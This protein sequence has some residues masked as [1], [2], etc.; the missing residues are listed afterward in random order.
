MSVA[1]D[2][3]PQHT[4]PAFDL[5]ENTRDHIFVTGRAGTGKS[6]LLRYFQENTHKRIVTLAPTGVAA[7][8]VRG[9]TIHSFFKFGPGVT[10]E[11]IKEKRFRK[12][13]IYKELDTIL[14]DE[15]SMVR[16]DL[17]D[18]VDTFLRMFGPDRK[19]P[20]GGIQMILIGDLHQLPPVV[21]RDEESIF[22]KT[23][24]LAKNY[25]KDSQREGEFYPGM[26]EGPFF[27]NA[28]AFEKIQLRYI[29]LQT[30]YRQSD[31]SFVEILDAIRTGDVTD[32][33]LEAINQRVEDLE[34]A[35]LD[36]DAEGGPSYVY[37]ATTNAIVER[38]NDMK[39]KKLA[40]TG[41]LAFKGLIRGEFNTRDLPTAEKLIIKPGAQVMLL[42]N[43]PKDRWVNGD[44]GKV[45][46]IQQPGKQAKEPQDDRIILDADGEPFDPDAE[47]GAI[48]TFQKRQEEKMARFPKI[49]VQLTDGREVEV[50]PITWD[51]NTFVYNQEDQKIES[52]II[53][54]FMQYP[55][56]L[57]WAVTVHK[58][59]GKT[60]EKVIVDFGNGTF[61]HG[62]AYVALSRATTLEGMILRTPL[63][64]HHIIFDKRVKEFHEKLASKPFKK[65]DLF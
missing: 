10:V 41:G 11:N 1:Q 8:N 14:I 33:Q 6:T 3:Q 35:M 5:L 54:S 13:K 12:S 15:V 58:G 51:R 28:H 36:D 34:E 43:D 44:I 9:E 53:G 18:C 62:Q 22:D 26:Y 45:I 27:F 61:A 63:E 64:K 59:Q 25:K 42:N 19:R 38:V 65:E 17:L 39:I 7:L 49:I 2:P 48:E 21:S 40:N 29:E 60:F 31:K 23:S 16:A 56:K 24:H 50:S 32:E 4:H 47:L 55:L 37:L 20:F 30:V 57:A 46:E 52:R